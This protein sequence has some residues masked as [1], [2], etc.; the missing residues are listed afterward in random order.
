MS[1]A[2][3]TCAGT[4]TWTP[5]YLPP[6]F[7]LY[8]LS[9]CNTLRL[10]LLM[11]L[12]PPA[13]KSGIR[14]MASIVAF[15]PDVATNAIQL[16]PRAMTGV[17]CRSTWL[18]NWDVD[19]SAQTTL[20][21]LSLKGEKL[22]GEVLDPMLLESRDKKN[23]LCRDCPS[24]KPNQCSQSSTF[25]GSRF[26]SSSSSTSS[27]RSQHPGLQPQKQFI[28]AKLQQ[29]SRFLLKGPKHQ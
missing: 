11:L 5:I 20:V 8:C 18:H 21:S 9:R 19:S 3:L 2:I 13:A 23:V 1:R 22:F 4:S 28:L 27:S 16:S 15:V 29:R 12:L 24:S 10:M 14:C 17:V 25:C 7:T 26:Q 6:D